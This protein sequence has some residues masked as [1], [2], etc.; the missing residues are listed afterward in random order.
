MTEKDLK[1]LSRSDLLELLVQEVK[2]NESLKQEL[3]LARAKLAEQE[4]TIQSAGSIAEAALK[5]SGIFEDAQ[6]AADIYLRNLARLE[7]QQALRA[8][9]C[10]QDG[11]AHE[12]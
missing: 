12:D 3:S 2:E 7:R 6:A 9:A 11:E 10:S 1:K 8:A 5:L 4:I